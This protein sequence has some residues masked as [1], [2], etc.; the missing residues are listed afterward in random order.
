MFSIEQKKFIVKAFARYQSAATVRREFIWHYKIKGR[1]TKK[2][3]LVLFA[4]IR[5]QF[6]N[7][8]T[9][10]R[11][12]TPRKKTKRTDQAKDLV[13][14]CLEETSTS[15]LRRVAQETSIKYTTLRKI[16]KE[17]LNLKFYHYS[18]VQPLSET[19][20]SQRIQFCNWLLEQPDNFVQQVIWTDEK[21]FCLKQKPHRRNDGVWS[22]K[23]PHLIVETNDRNDL[24]V[25]LF[26]A[27][28]NGKIP[29][30]HAF[31]DNTGRQQSVDG[32]CYLSMLQD[33]VWPKLRHCA[34]RLSLWWMQD[35]AM[36]HCTLPVLRFLEKKFGNRV[37]SRRTAIPWPAHSPD[38]NVLDFHFWALAQRRVFEV[39]PATIDEL[40]TCIKDFAG[41]YS[42]ES[43]RKACSS[44]LK[45]ASLCLEAQGGHFQHQL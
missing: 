29:V 19:H 38:L 8:G 33:S 7:D 32:S 30:V 40:V 11:K 44:V 39:K 24:K 42:E 2:F 28:V 41:S 5:D 12:S 25:M 3:K 10:L 21:T 16:V 26:V 14:A 20:K 22:K 23:N 27:I 35:G 4:R 45:R 43:L 13:K 18:S 1:A 37:I 31:L 17:D 34:T 6:D 9:V 15:S 36:P